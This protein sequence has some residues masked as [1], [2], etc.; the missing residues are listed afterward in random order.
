M[1]SVERRASVRRARWCVLA[2]V[3]AGVVTFCP[4]RRRRQDADR[5]SSRARSR[6]TRAATC[7]SSA[8]RSAR[9]TRSPRRAPTSIVK[10]H[11]DAEVQ[12][13]GRRQGRDRLAVDRR[14]P[15]RPAHPGLHR[16]RRCWPTARRSTQDRTAVPLELD[17]IYSSLDD[18]TV[19]LGPNGANK[20]GALTDLLDTTARELRRP[21]REVP[22]DD[23][24][25][26]PAQ[27]DARR[28]QG[29]AVRLGPRARGLRR[30]RSPAT[31]ARCAASTTRWPASPRCSKGERGDLAA[32]L[33]NLGDRDAAR[34]PASSATTARSSARNITGL[35]RITQILVKQRDAL[36]ETL[37]RRAAGAQQ[38][39]PDLQPAG[40][41][42][43][44]P[45]Q[46]R[47]A[48]A[49]RS[50]P[51]RR[52]SCAAPRPGRPGR[53][54][55]ATSSSSSLGQE[56]ARGAR[57]AAPAARRTTAIDPTLGGLVEVRPMTRRR[58]RRCSLVACSPSRCC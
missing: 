45:R 5:A 46:H 11:Y 56:P 47:R 44:H 36:A 33:H 32:A 51:T 17:Q 15:L 35:D 40:R 52:R 24:G 23:Q 42:P 2:L 19:A 25:L 13:P 53:R 50:S 7:G 28:Q 6:S 9:S 49:T 18:L 12:G 29:R 3:V 26:Q 31:T 10:M 30:T 21:G 58:R 8:C 1:A 34:S 4:R 16:R 43:R 22:P 39:G 20:K 27:R 14:R 55:R 37:Q 38:P 41:H 54:S 57:P 48:R